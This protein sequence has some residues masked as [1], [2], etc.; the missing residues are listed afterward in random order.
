MIKNTYVNEDIKNDS[1]CWV[2][3]QRKHVKELAYEWS[4][5]ALVEVFFNIDLHLGKYNAAI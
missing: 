5:K 2:L 3:A 4:W 1:F